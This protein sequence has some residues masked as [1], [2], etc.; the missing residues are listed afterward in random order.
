MYYIYIYT[1]IHNSICL[2]YTCP[3]KPGVCANSS[4]IG[5]HSDGDQTDVGKQVPANFCLSLA[6][7][8]LAN[9]VEFKGP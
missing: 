8:R 3:L 2:V 1:F 9:G 6:S 5:R 4:A 7:R